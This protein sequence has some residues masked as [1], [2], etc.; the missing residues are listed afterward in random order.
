MTEDQAYDLCSKLSGSNNWKS[1]LFILKKYGYIKKSIVDEAEELLR[2]WVVDSDI[3]Y[4]KIM[5][6]KA[7]DA[8][9]YLKAENERLKK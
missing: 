4:E 7:L 9:K 5:I 2:A 6:G 3:T 8:I 1:D